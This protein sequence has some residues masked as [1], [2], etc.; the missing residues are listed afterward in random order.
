MVRLHPLIRDTSARF[1]RLRLTNTRGLD[2]RTFAFDHDLTW[3][4]FFMTADGEVLGRFGGRDA[5]QPGAY[6]SLKGL[7]ASMESALRRFD[8]KRPAFK[9]P[10]GKPDRPED[11]PAA[12][13]LG[14]KSCIHCHH[15]HEFR[16]DAKQRAGAWNND[17]VHVYP[18]PESLGILLDLDQ[19][20]RV[21]RV[22]AG[23]AA[24]KA[25]LIADDLLDA[26]ND[27]R[28]FSRAD[29]QDALN[30]IIGQKEVRMAWQRDKIAMEGK[31]SLPDGWHKSDVSWRWSLKSML[32]EPGVAGDD[33]STD[34][35]KELGLK[36]GVL[37]FRQGIFLAPHARQAGVQVNDVILGFEGQPTNMNARQFEAH[38]RLNHRPGAEVVV[39][40]LRGKERLKLK[41]K[42]AG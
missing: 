7:K 23:S 25:G 14:A 15:L 10:T 30:R 41:M 1:V 13:K 22:E 32:P 6:H 21:V 9:P 16:R 18:W 2:L 17:D 31:A 12:E 28:V 42:L 27:Q 38:V 33:L 26:V 19:P 39:D 24:Q 36:P 20:N 8:E 29:V 34:E 3:F 11:S 4:A 40:V 37:A 35:R 5:D